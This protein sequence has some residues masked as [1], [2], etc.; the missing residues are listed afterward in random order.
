MIYEN[1]DG[2]KQQ[3]TGTTKKISDFF[4]KKQE[5]STKGLFKE[6]RNVFFDK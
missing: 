1:M 2:K 4:S 5:P 6:L 3:K